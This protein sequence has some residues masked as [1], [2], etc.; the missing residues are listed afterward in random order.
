M[1]SIPLNG[2]PAP[3]RRGTLVAAASP[4]A[5]RLMLA[6]ERASRSVLDGGWWPRSWDPSAEVP[7]LV[8][9]L[10]AKYG[11]IRQMMLSS[12]FWEGRFRRLVVGEVVVRLGWFASM[13]PALLIAITDAGD[14]IDLL[15]VPPSTTQP[16]AEQAMRTAADPDNLTRAQNVLASTPISPVSNA[17]SSEAKAVW[18]NE[19]GSITANGKR[20]S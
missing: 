17:N 13:D 2:T 9:A 11:R 1:S 8:V 14:Q 3:D 7:G 16:T 12:S 19:G 5:P 10:S 6:T 18:D 20:R 15:V 4:P